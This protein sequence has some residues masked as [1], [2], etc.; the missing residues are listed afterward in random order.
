[1]CDICT[2]DIF[3]ITKLLLLI[4]LKDT[5]PK[6]DLECEDHN[7]ERD[8]ALGSNGKWSVLSSLRCYI[9]GN[10]VFTWKAHLCLPVFPSASLASLVA[11]MVKNLPTMWEDLGSI[12]GSGRSPGGQNGNPLQYPCLDN[13]TDRG[14]WQGT[15]HGVPKRWTWLAIVVLLFPY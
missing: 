8:Q 5:F 3:I 12:P 6:S 11:Q 2:R 14:A 1:M 10:E 7:N 15:V 4:E 13:C 9:P